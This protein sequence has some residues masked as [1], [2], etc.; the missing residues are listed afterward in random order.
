MVEEYILQYRVLTGVVYQVQECF[1][2]V[3]EGYILQYRV[4]TGV[5]YQV[6]ECF[7][8]ALEE[9]I[10]AVQS[11]HWCCILDIVLLFPVEEYILEDCICSAKCSLVL[12]IRYSVVLYLW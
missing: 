1:F 12:W 3:V 2:P 9:Y 6:Q 5:V 11:P 8:P 4:L 7:L 10:P